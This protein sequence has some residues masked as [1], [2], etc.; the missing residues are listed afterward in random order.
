MGNEIKLPH[1]SGR[2]AKIIILCIEKH[3]SAVMKWQ[4]MDPL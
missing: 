3:K 1:H 2:A 4:Q